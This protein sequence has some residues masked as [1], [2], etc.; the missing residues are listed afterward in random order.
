LAQEAK[1]AL[2]IS[3]NELKPGGREEEAL[4]VALGSRNQP[5]LE[6]TA[7]FPLTLPESC[8]DLN[9]M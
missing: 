4:L 7:A 1:Q 6:K 9:R 5:G 3:P 8:P 2:N